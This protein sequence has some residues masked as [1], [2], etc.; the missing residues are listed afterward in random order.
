MPGSV[1]RLRMVRP[2]KI[3]GVQPLKP[4]NFFQHRQRAF[5]NVLLI[6]LAEARPR[7]RMKTLLCV[8]A[9]DSPMTTGIVVFDAP[10]EL[11]D[12]IRQAVIPAGVFIETA[13]VGVFAERIVHD[14]VIWIIRVDT[15]FHRGGNQPCAIKPGPR[16]DPRAI[17]KISCAPRPPGFQL[18]TDQTT[19]LA[20]ILVAQDL[21][22]QLFFCV[23]QSLLVCP[24]NRPIDGG[25]LPHHDAPFI[26]QS[27]HVFVVRIMREPDKI[28][29]QFFRPIE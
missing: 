20:G 21:L 26:G 29:V 16:L 18:A 9:E 19:T 14:F 7:V 27:R 28:T 12:F 10:A 5:V 23:R 15:H 11:V 22:A 17:S 25:F 8:R 6:L 4:A 3:H 24:L 2:H 1:V 13:Q